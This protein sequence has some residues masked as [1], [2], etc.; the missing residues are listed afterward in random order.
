MINEI[1]LP[2][3]GYENCYKISNQGQVKSLSRSI[4]RTTPEKILKLQFNTKGYQMVTL[5]NETGRKQHA[6]QR[7]VAKA[8]IPNPENKPQVNH[9]DGDKTNNSVDNLEWSTSK[10]NLDHAVKLGLKA[11][12]KGESNSMSKLTAETIKLAKTMLLQGHTLTYI[13]Q[14]LNVHRSTIGKVT[15]GKSWKHLENENI[16]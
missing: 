1:W 14:T 15:Q 2:I 13:G 7:L 9:I 16:A 6:I 4:R 5:Y 8:F 3:I 12:A 11:S 10:E